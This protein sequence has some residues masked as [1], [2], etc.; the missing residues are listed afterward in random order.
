MFSGQQGIY[1]WKSGKAELLTSG[2]GKAVLS[3][4]QEKLGFTRNGQAYVW[5]LQSKKEE[6]LGFGEFRSWL[7]D[8][9][10]ILLSQMGLE[11]EEKLYLLELATKKKIFLGR[12]YGTL[13]YP[14]FSSDGNQ[15]VWSEGPGK[16]YFWDL[17]KNERALIGLGSNPQLSSDKKQVLYY[18]G[19]REDGLSRLGVLDLSQKRDLTLDYGDYACWS[20][21]SKY[22]A[23]QQKEKVYLIRSDGQ[24]KKFLGKGREKERDYHLSWSPTGDKLSFYDGTYLYLIDLKN[25]QTYKLEGEEILGWSWSGEKVIIQRQHQVYLADFPGAKVTLVGCGNYLGWLPGGQ[26]FLFAD[27]KDIYL[28]NDQGG[29]IGAIGKGYFAQWID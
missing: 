18:G 20:P 16:I 22:L 25:K 3:P 28:Y 7:A 10:M 15:T 14:Y 4:N 13:D 19:L 17:E 29:R 5:D 27:G 11:E 23:Y 9:K 6:R 24:G 8:G 1:L 12:F 2:Q 26:K 21:N